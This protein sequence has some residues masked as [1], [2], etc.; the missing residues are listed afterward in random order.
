MILQ[1]GRGADFVRCLDGPPDPETFAVDCLELLDNLETIEPLK[2]TPQTLGE[3]IKGIA[4]IGVKHERIND[5]A[6]QLT[7]CAARLRGVLR[8]FEQQAEREIG[9]GS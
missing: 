9:G 4:R 5:V 8:D 1:L 7:N 3:A 6:S 2:V